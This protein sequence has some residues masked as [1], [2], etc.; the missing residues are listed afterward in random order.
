M[1][2]TSIR[3]ND[4][5]RGEIDVAYL[6]AGDA[7]APLALCLHGFPD[8]AWT[9]EALLPELADAGFHAVAPWLRGYAPTSIPDSGVYELPILARDALE[10]V[11]ALAG[12]KPATL[13]GHDWGGAIV[14]AFCALWPDRVRRAVAMAIPHV[15]A[16]AP[17]LLTNYEQQK[18]SFYMFLFQLEGLAE[19]VVG[20][21]DLA[22]VENLISDWSPNW[23]RTELDHDRLVESIG[24]PAN[25]AAALGYY[26]QMINPNA[27]KTIDDP[28]IDSLRMRAS[29]LISTPTL[30]IMGADDGCIDPAVIGDQK[31]YF[32]GDYDYR[33]VAGVGHFMLQDDADAVIPL[34]VDWLGR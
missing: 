22:F 28:Q 26:R 21:N 31:H 9:F 4:C 33:L 10:L 3:R 30:Q 14:Y 6:E 17:A 24:S 23:K 27:R 34:I 5:T 16:M 19:Q 15:N 12:D 18:R 20:F 32:A 13:I 11:D 7:G 8:H 29:G 25:M 2:N 1:T